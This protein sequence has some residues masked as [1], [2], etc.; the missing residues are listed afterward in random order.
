[1]GQ[2]G[3][4]LEDIIYAPIDIVRG[5][6]H[7]IDE[8]IG[9]VTGRNLQRRELGRAEERRRQEEAR[10]D[11]LIADARAEEEIADIS[12]SQSAASTRRG[13]RISPTARRRSLTNVT[14]EDEDRDLL[15][16]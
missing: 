9:E 16:V 13:R 3:N 6:G 14:G 8:G 15:G 1:M 2:R 12:A 7:A 10:R 5:V 11:Q 4:V